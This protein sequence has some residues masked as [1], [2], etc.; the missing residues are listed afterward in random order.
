MRIMGLDIGTKRIGVAL[1]DQTRTLAQGKCVVLR[2]S[3]DKAISE[4]GQLIKSCDVDEVVVGMPLN[5]NGTKGSRAQDSEKFGKK[6]AV[7]SGVSVA[8]WDERLS[9]KEIEDILIVASVRRKKRKEL[10][11][12]MAAQVILQSYLDFSLSTQQEK[13]SSPE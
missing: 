1:S 12:K 13:D 8:Y 2:K 10:L 11:D 5:M 6:L 9:T 3:D 7:F 4:I